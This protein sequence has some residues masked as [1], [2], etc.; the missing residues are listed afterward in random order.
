MV[1]LVAVGA[2]VAV[3]SLL[4]GAAA[5]TPDLFVQS[6]LPRLAAVSLSGAAL[7]LAGL[8][9]QQLSANRFVSPDTASTVD[10]GALGFLAGLL[11]LPQ[12][13]LVVRTALSFAA[14]L[15]GTLLFLGVAGRLGARNSVLVPVLGL[16]LG[17]AV[18]A[19]TTAWAWTADLVQT[20]GTWTSGDFSLV[21]EGRWELLWIIVPTL[22]AAA[23]FSD[24]LTVAGLGEDPA[25]ALGLPYRA[26]V[27]LG[28]A[29]AALLT[30]AVLAVGGVLPFL[31]LVVPNL[32][33]RLWG[34]HLRTNLPLAAAG[35][36]VFLLVCD[37]AGRL[38]IF[39][40]EVPLG[41]TA[42]ITGAAAFLALHL[43]SPGR[44]NRG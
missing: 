13:P 27:V 42:G 4:V 12:A 22:G 40:F 6:R 10:W 28:V 37:L 24:A 26:V 3:P 41:V 2:V 39:P 1:G 31:G 19:V 15:G 43:R 17:A 33:T 38:M 30:S 5:L 20:L 21:V 44:Q 8:I 29:L 34:D 18:G 14:A 7:A 11:L 23:W 36:A 16:A 32:V 25:R 9:L 35:G